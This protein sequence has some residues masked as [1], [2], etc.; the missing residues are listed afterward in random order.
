[1]LLQKQHIIETLIVLLLKQYFKCITFTFD[2]FFFITLHQLKLWV[3]F[4]TLWWPS[5]SSH[6]QPLH[7]YLSNDLFD[8]ID[9]HMHNNLHAENII[10]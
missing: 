4:P 5:D 10:K 7:I 3:L 2:R 1:M 9:P 8:P 6:V